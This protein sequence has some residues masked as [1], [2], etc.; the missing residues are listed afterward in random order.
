MVHKD[1]LLTLSPYHDT[2]EITFSHRGV[3]DVL[4]AVAAREA[5]EFVPWIAY[6]LFRAFEDPDEGSIIVEHLG[7]YHDDQWDAIS[8]AHWLANRAGN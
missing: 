8:T 2:I 7:S 4:Y 5:N 1:D 6:S 3:D